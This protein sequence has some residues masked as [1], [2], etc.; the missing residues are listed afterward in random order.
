M[1]GD[2]SCEFCEHC[3]YIG[4]GDFWCDEK[5]EIIASEFAIHDAQVCKKY[6]EA[7]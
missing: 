7:E 3:L 1:G 2:K 5:R 6:E 4:E